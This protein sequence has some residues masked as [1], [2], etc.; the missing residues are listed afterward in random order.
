MYRTIIDFIK[1]WDTEVESTLKVFRKLNDE[2]LTYKPNE[3]VRSIGRLVWHITQTV[4]EMPYSAGILKS[5]DLAGKEIPGSIL[6][7]CNI[8]QKY[9]QLV[10]KAV[11]DSWKDENLLE[12]ILLYG[13]SWERRKV[14]SALV[15]HQTHH[16][17]QLSVLMR[18][19]GIEVPG[20]Y[21]PSKEEWSNYGMETQ[22]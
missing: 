1:E 20:V 9:G 6:D 15:L 12:T 3:N 4:S 18:L 2:S 14:L 7:I 16:R 10:S 19:N 22:E 17:G 11:H 5:D 21:G 8:Y 13:Q